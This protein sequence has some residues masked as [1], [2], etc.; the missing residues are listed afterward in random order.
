MA[1]NRLWRTGPEALRHHWGIGELPIS[2]MI[3]LLEAKGVRIFSLAI[4]AHEVDAFSMWKAATPFVFLNNNKS[5]EHSRYDAA[6][7][8]GH[9]V[10]HRH[11]G[12]RGREAEQEANAFASAFL[13][14]RASVIA[15]APRFP[16][17]ATLVKLKRI[18]TTS[19]AALNYRLHAVGMLSDWQYRVLCIQISR[20]GY[21][22]KEPNEAPREIS[23]VLPKIFSALHQDGVSRPGVARALCIPQSELECL[24]F[25]LAMASIEGGRKGTSSRSRLTVVNKN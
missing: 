1:S 2:N 19:V 10:L 6:H 23:Q 13:M 21:R 22:T 3:H 18:W 12:P 5:S 17:V 15:H 14:P 20:N 9:L 8:L 7:E 11:G 4:D 24:M 16:T 25:G